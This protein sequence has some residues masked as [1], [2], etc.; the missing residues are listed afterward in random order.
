MED[1]RT[2]T[3]LL[4]EIESLKARLNGG[5][6]GMDLLQAVMDNSSAVIYIKDAEG[7]F[8]F[9]N[10][11]YIEK[12]RV[13]RGDIIGRTDYD[14]FPKEIADTFRANDRKVLEAG[15]PLEFEEEALEPDGQPHTYFTVKFPL[16]GM[17][18]VVCGISTYMTER[19]RTE[20]ALKKSDERLKEAQSISHI[21]SWDWDITGNS[22][23]WSDE[24]YRIFGLKPQEFG[25]TYES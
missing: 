2:K 16:S 22:L 9:M 13:D 6:G 5:E 10:R 19:K 11:C 18:G 7:R 23:F 25:A 24:I 14:I 15:R 8:L 4:A 20:E 3:E 17:P 21:G 12:F 1:K